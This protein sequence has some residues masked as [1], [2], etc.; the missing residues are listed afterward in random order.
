MGVKKRTDPWRLSYKGD[1]QRTA[2]TSYAITPNRQREHTPLLRE[3]CVYAPES[4]V[5]LK[6]GR[7][8][9]KH[10]TIVFK[11]KPY[12]VRHHTVPTPTRTQ[13]APPPGT[14]F[15]RSCSAT[16]MTALWWPV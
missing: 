1:I 10:R 15:I 9:H 3:L 4:N 13:A 16:A 6:H 2:L 7:L 14:V 11:L 5:D 12:S 8:R